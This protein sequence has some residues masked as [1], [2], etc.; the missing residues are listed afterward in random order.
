[1]YE[2]IQKVIEEN[3]RKHN[4]FLPK[5][6]IIELEKMFCDKG[7]TSYKENEDGE[8]KRG[9]SK[10]YIPIGENIL[11]LKDVKKKGTRSGGQ[12][13]VLSFWKAPTESSSQASSISYS[14]ISCYHMVQQYKTGIKLS[15]SWFKSFTS[16]FTEEQLESLRQYKGK[17]IK[18]LI[19]HEHK[20]YEIDDKKYSYVSPF[21][22]DAK[23]VDYEYKDIDYFSLI[24]KG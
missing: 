8:I 23:T 16:C 3:G 9:G 1:M 5:K 24:K 21:I 11:K 15:Q 2:D 22:I 14:L 17:E 10:Y 4:L 12:M 6:N 13:Y 20:I 19:G 18:A 7:K